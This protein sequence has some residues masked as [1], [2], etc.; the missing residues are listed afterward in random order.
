MAVLVVDARSRST[1]PVE[2]ELRDS[3]ATL[4]SAEPFLIVVPIPRQPL[5]PSGSWLGSTS[6]RRELK[7]V[8]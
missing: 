5:E 8:A 3:K 4:I 6:S 1:I 7:G 2:F